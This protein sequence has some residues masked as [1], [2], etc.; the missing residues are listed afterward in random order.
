ML[1]ARRRVAPSR[2][3]DRR[4][5][6]VVVVVL[7]LVPVMPTQRWAPGES[8]AIRQLDLGDRLEDG[9][10]LPRAAR[11]A[12]AS[13]RTPGEATTS[14]STVL[15]EPGGLPAEGSRTPG[16]SSAEPRVRI[17]SGPAR[18]STVTRHAARRRAARRGDPGALESRRPRSRRGRTAP[19]SIAACD[20]ASPATAKT[21]ADDPE[22]HDHLGS[23]PSRSELEVVVDRVPS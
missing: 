20:V 11:S 8:P 23:R 19:L 17:P 14:H 18:S 4:R 1:P 3:E 13:T 22:A 10:P 7:P 9:L 2:S 16:G 21:M 6:S 5:S 15:D 12:A